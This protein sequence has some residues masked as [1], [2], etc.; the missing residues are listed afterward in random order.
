MTDNAWADTKNTTL[1]G[2][3]TDNAIR[4]IRIRP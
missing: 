3:L 4:H 1:A 2:L